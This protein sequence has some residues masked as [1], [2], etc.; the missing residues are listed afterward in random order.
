MNGA[1]R[2]RKETAAPAPLVMASSGDEFEAWQ[3]HLCSLPSSAFRPGISIREEYERWLMVRR[4]ERETWSA[5]ARTNVSRPA[6]V[7]PGYMLRCGCACAPTMESD[8]E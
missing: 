8:A 2:Q 4:L 1:R 6:E 7:P 5:G 3:R